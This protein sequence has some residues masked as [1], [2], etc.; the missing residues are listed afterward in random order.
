ML[1]GGGGINGSFLSAGLI[2]EISLLILPVADGSLNVPT[3][4]DRPTGPATRLSLISVEQL[5]G[6]V[7]YLRYRPW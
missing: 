5:E 6:D 1:E 3:T 4:F 2:D 7:V